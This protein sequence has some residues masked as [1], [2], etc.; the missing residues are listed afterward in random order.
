[1][2]KILVIDG[3][4]GKMGRGIVSELKK[5]YPDQELM[6]IGTNSIATAA[7]LKTGA[8][9]GATGENPVVVNC[10]DAQLIIGPIGILCADALMGEITPTMATA[11]GSS[12]AK[13]LLIPVNRCNNFIVG[14]PELPLSEYIRQV[15]R[16][17]GQHLS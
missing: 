16:Q 13:K 8:D 9:Y 5:N 17:V 6:A 10:R 1:M 3:Q 14:C 4:G 2:M 7:M 11:I 15:C 12:L